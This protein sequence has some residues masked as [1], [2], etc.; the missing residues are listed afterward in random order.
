MA[1][2]KISYQF[3]KGEATPEALMVALVANP[4]ADVLKL[5]LFMNGDLKEIRFLVSETP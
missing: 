1:K 3:K 2:P 5:A 4:D